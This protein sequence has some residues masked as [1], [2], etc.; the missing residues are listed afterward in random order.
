MDI[1]RLRKLSGLNEN[2]SNLSDLLVQAFDGDGQFIQEY[3]T[4]EEM[5]KA[6]LVADS[7]TRAIT[8]ALGLSE[9]Y[10]LQVNHTA[11]AQLYRNPAVIMVTLKGDNAVVYIDD[12]QA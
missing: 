10:E 12:D 11:L 1:E 3:E 7:A 8:L 6:D 2:T 4:P 9:G 5:E